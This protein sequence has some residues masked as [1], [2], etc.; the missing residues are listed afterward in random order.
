[1][2][3]LFARLEMQGRRNGIRLGARDFSRN[4]ENSHLNK[5][6]GTT[7]TEILDTVNRYLETKGIRITTGTIVDA[8]FIHAPS[9][10]KS[11]SGERDPAMH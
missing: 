9:S 5:S 10:T 7:L 8:T 4:R 3:V 11:A 2:E 1:M 6:L